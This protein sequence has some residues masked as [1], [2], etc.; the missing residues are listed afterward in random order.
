MKRRNFLTTGMILGANSTF[1]WNFGISPLKAAVSDWP[2][3]IFHLENFDASINEL[4][5]TIA[6]LIERSELVK[7]DVKKFIEDGRTVPITVISNLENTKV[8]T[9]LSDKNPNPVI[10]RFFISADISPAIS[11]RIKMGG[12]GNIYALINTDK[13][14]YLA[15]RGI[16]VTSGG[17]G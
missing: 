14:I 6:D 4:S 9:I 15:Q 11:T 8:I 2:H 13:N 10:A 16:Q 1:L 12:S 7:I 17:C 5:G 3:S